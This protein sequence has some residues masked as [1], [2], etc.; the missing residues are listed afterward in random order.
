LGQ[1]HAGLRAGR[2]DDHPPLVAPTFSGQGRGVLDELE[3][4]RAGEELDGPVIV[5]DNDREV[6]KPH[7]QQRTAARPWVNRG[8]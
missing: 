5:I 7:A 4:E 1:E 6:L 2:A 3:T 8:A